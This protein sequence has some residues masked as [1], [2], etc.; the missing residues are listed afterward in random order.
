MAIVDHRHAPRDRPVNF[1]R[2][3]PLARLKK[4][5]MR[6]RQNGA[7][8]VQRR[9]FEIV[10]QRLI[11]LA[12]KFKQ[13]RQLRANNS[14]SI[15]HHLD[16]RGRRHYLVSQVQAAHNNFCTRVKN[17][18][19]RLGVAPDIEFGRRRAIAEPAATHQRNARNIFNEIWRNSQRQR[20][21]RQRPSRHQPHT[22]VRPRRIDNKV[23]CVNAVSISRRRRKVCA[24]HSAFAVNICRMNRLGHQRSPGARMQLHRRCTTQIKD[25]PGVFCC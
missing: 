23:H 14:V 7:N 18:C 11:H 13:P 15:S 16:S 12:K 21:V 19:R 1:N 3:M 6:Q 17:R 8:I 24:V 20:N 10:V 4:L 25:D 22:G 5:R 2:N 9:A